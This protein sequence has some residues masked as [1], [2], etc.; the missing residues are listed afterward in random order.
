MAGYELLALGMLGLAAFFYTMGGF[1]GGS[2]FLLILVLTGL[3]AG[4]AATAGLIINVFSAA[5][6]LTRWKIHAA[7]GLLWFILGSVPSAFFSGLFAVPDNLLRTIMGVAIVVGGISVLLATSPLRPV[8]LG[9]PAKVGIGVAIGLVTGLTG[10]GGGV[11]LAP[12]LILARIA[13][14]K[15]TAATTTIFILANSL[16]GVVARTPRLVEIM[17]NPLVLAVVPV[18]LLASQLGSYIG[19]RRLTQVN[20]RRVIG[21]ILMVLGGYLIV[22]SV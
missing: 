22:T 18:V 7:R 1:A 12:V 5:S 9:A 8:S 15:T 14:P 20:V 11:Y 16:S 2:M 21:L 4:Q 19:S 6:S 13:E 17:P 10:I 3:P